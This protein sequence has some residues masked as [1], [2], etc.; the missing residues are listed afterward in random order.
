MKLPRIT[1][2]IKNTAGEKL[3]CYSITWTIISFQFSPVKIIN[4]DTNALPVELK[5]YLD[6]M[7][8]LS[9][10]SPV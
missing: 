4:T 8:V 6:V 10:S 9:F 1:T 5:L 3:P 7:P 2:I